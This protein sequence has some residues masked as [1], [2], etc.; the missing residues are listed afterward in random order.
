MVSLVRLSYPHRWEDVERIFVGMKR[1]KL[2][3]LFYWFLDYMIENWSYLILNNRDYWTPQMPNMA[4]AIEM[5]LATLPKIKNHT[6]YSGQIK[7]KTL[8]H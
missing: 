6:R 7:T 1:W 8:S 4:R 2:Q 5:K 3:Y